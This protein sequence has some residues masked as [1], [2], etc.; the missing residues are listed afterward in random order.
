MRVTDAL[1]GEHA[2]F[3]ALFDQVEAVASS[4]GAVTQVEAATA[5]LSV[6][7]GSHAALEDE[8][9]FAALESRIGKEGPLLVMRAEHEEMER[10]L[11]KIEDARDLEQAA[12]YIHEALRV[13]RDHFRKE[14]KV[15]FPMAEQMLDEPTL[16]RLGE[17]WADARHVTV[18]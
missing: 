14:E 4:A 1:L 15:L 5:V 16:V 12:G 10:A 13:A 11:E 3:Y 8:L 2:V 6:V 9:L 18:A 7:V 17:I